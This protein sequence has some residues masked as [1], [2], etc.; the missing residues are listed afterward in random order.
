MLLDFALLLIWL[1]SEQ[2]RVCGLLPC[3][4]LELTVEIV[5]ALER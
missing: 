1:L 2:H 3:L 5:V 4:W